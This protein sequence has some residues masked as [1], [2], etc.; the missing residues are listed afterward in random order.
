MIHWSKRPPAVPVSCQ[1]CPVREATVC[2]PLEG[3]R[4][5]IVQRFKSGDRILPAGS[6]LYRPGETCAELFN[7]L[8][9][10][11]MLYRVLES[12]RF[13]I[14]DF[15][16]PGAF[17]GYQPD[18]REPMLHGAE[19]LTDVSVCVF[20]RR[21]FPALIEKTPDLAGRLAW[22]TA[23]DTVIAQE[24]LTN[25][26]ARAARARIARLLLELCSRLRGRKFMLDDQVI[27]IPLTQQHIAM[28]ARAALEPTLVKCS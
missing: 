24:H 15:A 12:G 3:D 7:L 16:L 13:Q 9:G 27:E 10:W 5:E 19:C 4:L 28:R 21:S 23:R 2:Q 26:G 25:V 1:E 22:L 14:L 17:V 11:L 18:L 6:Q 20:P 8:D